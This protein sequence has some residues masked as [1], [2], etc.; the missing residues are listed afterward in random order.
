MAAPT[1]YQTGILTLTALSGTVFTEVDNGGPVP[2]RIPMTFGTFTA[3]GNTPVVVAAPKV[4]AA[5]QIYITL[6]T[7]SGTVGAI[8]IVQT[9]TVGTGF[10][11]VGA[12]LDLSLYNFMI[13]G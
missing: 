4:T 5:S 3:N 2:T 11:V 6:N 8:P 12:S 13:L 9:K 7:P 1:L 10:T